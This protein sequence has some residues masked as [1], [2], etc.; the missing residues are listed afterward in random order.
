MLYEGKGKPHKNHIQI[1]ASCTAGK[2]LFSS[3]P[4][5]FLYFLCTFHKERVDF[6]TNTKFK[7][8]YNRGT[9]YFVDLRKRNEPVQMKSCYS[10]HKRKAN[11]RVLNDNRKGETE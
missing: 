11:E 3:S 7:M 1:C 8:R 4:C 6:S 10:S 2:L 5:C 9:K